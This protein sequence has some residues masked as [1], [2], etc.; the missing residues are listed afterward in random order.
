[1]LIGLLW[2]RAHVF[3]KLYRHAGLAL[4]LLKHEV[5]YVINLV[6]HVGAITLQLDAIL[7]ATRHRLIAAAT[8]AHHWADTNLLG[9]SRDGIIEDLLL[10]SYLLIDCLRAPIVSDRFGV[11]ARTGLGTETLLVTLGLCFSFD[12][13]RNL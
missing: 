1:M 8:L 9:I 10:R 3:G 6:E 5:I 2:L 12:R 7:R 13:V 11:R 4:P